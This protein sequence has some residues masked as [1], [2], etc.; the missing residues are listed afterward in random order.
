M[1]TGCCGRQARFI[2]LTH[3]TDG[4]LAGRRPH[5]GYYDFPGPMLHGR[6]R[7]CPDGPSSNAPGDLTLSDDDA[8]AVLRSHVLHI[9]CL[10]HH[11]LRTWLR[12][13]P[14]CPYSHSGVTFAAE[15]RG[16]HHDVRR[17]TIPNGRM[18]WLRQIASPIGGSPEVS[19][20][21]SRCSGRGPLRWPYCYRPQRGGA[22]SVP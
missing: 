22:V 21:S 5:G 17:H 16:P 10:T 12:S 2:S 18:A 6:Q 14:S 7:R 9:P 8:F 13:C 20:A 4:S 1:C 15:Y 3:L 11:D 19:P